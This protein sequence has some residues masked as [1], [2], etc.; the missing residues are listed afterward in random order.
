MFNVALQQ[1]SVVAEQEMVRAADLDQQSS[2]PRQT[3]INRLDVGLDLTALQVG[4]VLVAQEEHEGLVQTRLN[5]A[6]KWT[7]IHIDA[8]LAPRMLRAELCG[9]R[10]AKGVTEYPRARH[11]EPPR[12]LAGWV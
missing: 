7:A 4:R 9:L 6:A 10:P 2:V 1:R 12:K 11:V 5:D 3:I 8:R